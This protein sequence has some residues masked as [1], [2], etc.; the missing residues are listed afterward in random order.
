[1]ELDPSHIES[2]LLEEKQDRTLP[3]SFLTRLSEQKDQDYCKLVGDKLHILDEYSQLEKEL[4]AK[5]QQLELDLNSSILRSKVL[6]APEN[7]ESPEIR[8]IMKQSINFDD[9]LDKRNKTEMKNS[10]I[11]LYK[12][13]NSESRLLNDST[14]DQECTFQPKINKFKHENEELNHS[15]NRLLWLYEESKDRQSKK[16]EELRKAQEN[17]KATTNFKKVSLNSKKIAIKNLEKNLFNTFANYLD[18]NNKELISFEKLGEALLKLLQTH[19]KTDKLPLEKMERKNMFDQ[20]IWKALSVPQMILQKEQDPEKVKFV[21]I[22]LVIDIFIIIL[23]SELDKHKKIELIHERIRSSIKK[24]MNGESQ[25]LNDLHYPM[26]DA[27]NP[28]YQPY[29]CSL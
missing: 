13:I 12:K 11:G 3:Q 19:E 27:G 7:T 16:N 15:K 25:I 26:Q 17:I 23:E 5:R 20:L 1:M 10:F 8:K 14:D 2:I 4:Q 24:T 21:P 22:A 6:N 9:H 28:S 29:S 18:Q